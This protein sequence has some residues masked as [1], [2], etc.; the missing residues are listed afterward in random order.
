MGCSFKPAFALC[1]LILAP[2]FL[3]K[4][5]TSPRRPRGIY[6]VVNITDNINQQRKANPSADLNAY[7]NNLFQ[8]LLGNPAISGLT[9]QVHWDT[10]NPNAPGSANTYYWNY[11]DDAF[12]QAAA[13]NA[14][15]GEHT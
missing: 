12:T 5:Q 10:L 9:L 1:F 7:F 8:D 14:E 2:A 6:A 15:S 13:W 3:A 11:P 4:G